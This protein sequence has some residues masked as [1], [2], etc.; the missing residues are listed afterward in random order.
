MG[1]IIRGI[2]TILLILG[3]YGL[4]RWFTRKKVGQRSFRKFISLV[5]ILGGVVGTLA[6]GLNERLLEDHPY[7]YL[8]SLSFFITQGLASL[9]YYREAKVGLALLILTLLL[10]IPIIGTKKL[11]YSNQ[12]LFS[13]RIEKYNGKIVDIEPGSYVHFMYIDVDFDYVNVGNPKKDSGYGLNLI[14]L[15]TI[16]LLWRK[17]NQW[18]K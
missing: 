14:P 13:F 2:F 17:T 12:T 8:L 6:T 7:Q 11:S 5:I 3:L 1:D 4:Y 18:V 9:L 15:L 16:V 10:Q